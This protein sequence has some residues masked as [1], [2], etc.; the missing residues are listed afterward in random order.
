MVII[1]IA[2]CVFSALLLFFFFSSLRL[3]EKL[4]PEDDERHLLYSAR[5]AELNVCVI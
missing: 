2:I 1:T 5:K 4:R 3:R